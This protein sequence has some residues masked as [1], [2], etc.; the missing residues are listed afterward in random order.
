MSKNDILGESNEVKTDVLKKK[1]VLR[2]SSD[3]NTGMCPNCRN[4]LW[5]SWNTSQCPKCGQKIMWG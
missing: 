5:Q 1:S 3:T 2:T 4:F